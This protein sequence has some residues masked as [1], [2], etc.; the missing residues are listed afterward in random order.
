M[1]KLKNLITEQAEII[2][3]G[4]LTKLLATGA[5]MVASLLAKANIDPTAMY[6]QLKQHEGLKSKIYKDTEGHPT[7]GIGFNLD[8]RHNQEYL[9]KIGIDVRELQNGAEIGDGVIKLLYNHSLTQAW[10][11]IHELVPNFQQLPTN[12]Q[13]VL[14]DMSFNL[15]KP[16]LSKFKN[17]LGAVNSGD[18]KT[19]ADEMIDSEWYH[20]VKSRGKH[21]VGMMRD[22]S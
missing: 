8:A 17:M 2:E 7:I 18:F 3:E 4:R 10:H 16:Q 19:A 6:N 22:A 20:Q 9:K 12:V 5:M 11:D 21:L 13:M 1:I 15:G 14:L